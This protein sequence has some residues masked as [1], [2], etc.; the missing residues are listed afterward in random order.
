M[1]RIIS[2]R[3]VYFFGVEGESEQSFVAWLQR[4]S[5]QQGLSQHYQIENLGGGGYRQM[6]NEML[7]LLRQKK[8]T[9][10]SIL[11]V[12]SD[13]SENGDDG[14]SIQE[15]RKQASKHKITVILQK[16]NIEGVFLRM[17]GKKVQRN[18]KDALIRKWPIYKKP[19]NADSITKKFG[20]NDLLRAANQCEELMLLVNELGF[21][22]TFP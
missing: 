1:K 12:D 20:L 14:M 4:L 18:A 22:S 8:Q 13:R 2:Q 19:M 16:P 17:L 5:D 9:R 3:T 10:H 21:N 11:V 7:K 6:L 15:L